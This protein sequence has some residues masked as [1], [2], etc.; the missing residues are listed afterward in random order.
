MKR[1]SIFFLLSLLTSC[2]S[3]P[4]ESPANSEKESL[5]PSS[6]IETSNTMDRT[7]IKDEEGFY[8]LP[9]SYLPEGRKEEG[10]KD[11][12]VSCVSAE[13]DRAFNEY[14]V[15]LND[16]RVAPYK[17]KTDTSH[18]FK[19]IGNAREDSA[20]RQLML[21]G[22][23]RVTIELKHPIYRTPT[24]RPLQS[25]V[26]FDRDKDFRTLSFTIYHPGQYTIEFNDHITKTLH[27]FV[28]S[29]S[30]DEETYKKDSSVLYFSKGIHDK[31]NDKRIPSDN[32]I[33]LSS[34]IKTVYLEQGAIVRASFFAYNLDGVKILGHGRIDGSVFV[35]NADTNQRQIPIDFQY[36]KN[37]KIQDVRFTDPAGWCLN[38]YF[39]NGVKVDNVKIITSR[40]NGDGIS[41]QSCKNVEVSRCF[42]RSFDDTLVVKNYPRYGNYSREGESEHIHFSDCILIT[43]LAQTREVGY[44]TIGEKRNDISFENITVLHA[45]HHAVFSIHNGNNANIDGVSYKNITV[46]DAA[47]GKGDG[48]GRLVDINVKHSSTWSD[49]WKKTS[50][51]SVSNVSFENILVNG[52]DG[53]KVIEG[54]ID[55]RDHTEHDVTGV[56]IKGFSVNGEQKRRNDFKTNSFVKGVTFEELGKSITGSTISY[57]YTFSSVL[58]KYSSFAEFL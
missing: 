27:L 48:N 16:K 6:E 40:A 30:E 57:L 45:Y 54:S 12:R 42:V 41:V 15:Y 7:L 35:R 25:R 8:I 10:K 43:D 55:E 37:V 11:S 28:D 24:I 2:S 1:K 20:L 36:C 58:E 44:E 47:M 39:L 31:T 17:A 33:R 34:S 22:Y 14:R 9:S 38:L 56:L 18:A 26:A 13:G 52:K 5:P 32:T 49:N 3:L 46:E 21:E 19:S 4:S 53:T 29:F 51:G 50:L 23:C